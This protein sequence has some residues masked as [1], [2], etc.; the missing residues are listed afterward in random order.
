M[1]ESKESLSNIEMVYDGPIS[2]PFA[3]VWLKEILTQLLL[4]GG[5]SL[6]MNINEQLGLSDSIDPLWIE[7]SV[8]SSVWLD[9][10]HRVE[11]HSSSARSARTTH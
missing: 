9:Q 3:D 8:K 5:F 6:A 4:S 7:I 1:Y 11:P 10:F 2:I